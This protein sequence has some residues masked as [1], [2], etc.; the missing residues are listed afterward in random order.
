M[1]CYCLNFTSP[2]HVD[3]R[4]TGFY[5]QSDHYIQSSTLSAAIVSSWALLE[6]DEAVS[7]AK[8]PDFLLSS[9]FPYYKIKDKNNNNLSTYFFL[10]RPVN[11][12]T[13][14]LNK[15]QISNNFKYIK[16]L[17]KI[18]W[19][20]SSLWNDIVT[21]KKLEYD[22]IHIISNVLACKKNDSDNIP[23]KFWEQEEKPRLYADRFTNQ[24]IDGKIFHFGRIHFFEN[25][26]DLFEKK[27]GLYFLAKFN[28]NETQIKFEA[29]LKLL[30]DSG[31]G[32]DRNSGNGLFSFEQNNNI[33]PDL[34]D[35]AKAHPYV[36]L[37]LLNPCINEQCN[38]NCQEMDCKINDWIG[39]SSYQLLTNAGWIGTSGKRRKSIR[40]F[41][42]GSC[43]PYKLK[44]RIVE[45]GES[46]QGYK[47]YRDGRGFFI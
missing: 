17:N 38:E 28:N 40:M 43:F 41:N 44:G 21:G 25:T 18:K 24:A 6:P 22:K 3:T 30:G 12:M 16:K 29:A 45:I 9:A 36:C 1:K 33:C 4:G 35:S 26:C 14:E 31:I 39:D 27:C 13:N 20:E 2:F 23:L 19:L 34:I 8:N 15:E 37:S 32:S 11:S 46:T 47:I 42:E 10:P 5:E 7:W